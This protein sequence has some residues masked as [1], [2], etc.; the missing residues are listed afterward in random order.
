MNDLIWAKYYN[1]PYWPSI[2]TSI[3]TKSHKAKKRLSKP[4]TKIMVY[5]LGVID[6]ASKP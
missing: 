6:D 4:R 5:F 3:Q 2:V 1:Y